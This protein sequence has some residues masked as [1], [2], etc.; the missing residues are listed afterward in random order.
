MAKKLYGI[1]YMTPRQL[2]LS[3]VDLN[4]F[5]IVED[6]T[7]NFYSNHT[8]E[9]QH[10]VQGITMALNGFL[11]ILKEY[12]VKNYRFWGNQQS[13]DEISARYLGE[14]IYVRTTLRV[15]WLNTS[16]LTYYKA[17]AIITHLDNFK[18]ISSS[19][20][21]LLSLGSE[22]VSLSQFSDQK[23]TSTWNIDLGSA[24]LYDVNAAL[25]PSTSNPMALLEDYIGSKLEHLKHVFANQTMSSNLIL[26]DSLIINKKFIPT[27]QASYT[28][29]LEE[30]KMLYQKVTNASDQFLMDYFEIDENEITSIASYFLLLYQIVKLT[31]AQNIILTDITV[32]DGLAIDR[33]QRTGLKKQNFDELI[34]TTA[35]NMATRY[36]TSKSHRENVTMIALHLFD[37]LKKLHHLGKR[38]RLLLHVSCIL[39]DIGNYINQQ[40]H[41]NH[42]AYILQSTKV[43][44][45]SNTENLIIAEIA[46]YHSSEAPSASEVHFKNL[47]PDV[48]MKVAKLS[49]LLRIADALDDS[50]EEKIQK[51]SVSLRETELIIF[52]YS[53]QNI[54]LEQWSFTNKAQLF[55]KVFGLK[56]TLKQ[57]RQLQ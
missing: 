41:Y 33:V 21:F 1:I 4:D 55:E 2:K 6:V 54:A 17:A 24:Q 22:R 19:L 45:L 32:S 9:Y 28:M 37:Q 47:N 25:K 27:D 48:Q 52:A 49:S 44:G 15:H 57:R 29:P 23:F 26:Q 8:Y 51:I 14:Q 50:R 11:L 46:R 56:A 42:S 20:T 13:L 34:L 16:Q 43:L 18:K 53:N 31:K 38:E 12:G 36:L 5:S 10:N 39:A 3:I 7:S 35:E 30:F 40:G